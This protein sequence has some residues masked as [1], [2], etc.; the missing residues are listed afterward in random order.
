MKK[1]DEKKTRDLQSFQSFKLN[2]MK[3]I[4]GGYGTDENGGP[5][6]P[7]QKPGKPGDDRPN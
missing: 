1:S 7:P 2:N 6:D 5:I 3:A 4:F